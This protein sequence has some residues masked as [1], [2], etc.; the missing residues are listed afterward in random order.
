MVKLEHIDKYF[1]RFKKNKIHVINDTSLELSEKGLVALLGPSGSGKTTLLN[2][3]GGLD[4]VR[5]GKIW[6]NGQQITNKPQISVDRIRNLNV[7]YIFQDYKLIDNLSVYENVSIVLKMIGIKDKKEIDKRVR[8]VLDKV[9]MLRYKKRPCSMLSGG[10]RQRVGIARAI[11]KNPNIIIADEPTGNLD[12]KNSIEIMNIIKSISKDKLVILVT[13]E[14]SLAKFYATRILELEDGKIIKDYINEN[15]QELN[16]ENSNS[17]YLRDYK[18]LCKYNEDIKVYS[19]TPNNLKINIVV[20][21]N[22]IYIE[23]LDNKKIEI[24]DDNS[25]LKMVDDHYKNFSKKELE[26]YEFDYQQIINNPKKLKYSSIFNPL[27][28]ITNGFQ[29]V[30]NYSILKKILLIGFFLSG[31]FILYGTSSIISTLTIKD[32]Q[33]VTMNKN[34]LIIRTKKIKLD[35]YQTYENNLEAEYILPTNSIIKLN[36]KDDSFYQS[37]K[38]IIPIEGSLTSISTIA[39]SDLV[40]GRMPVAEN[41]I[42]VDKLT[43]NKTI[44]TETAK[45]LGITKTKDFLEKTII[46]PNMPDFKIVGIVNK[47]SPSIYA[48]KNIFINLLHHTNTNQEEETD[49]DLG[50]QD[51]EALEFD[52]F[53]LYTNKVELKEGRWPVNDYETIVNINHKEEY[54]INKP[55]NKSIQNQ[56]LIVVGYYSPKDEMDTYLINNNMIKIKV[57]EKSSDISVYSN[58]KNKTL[59]IGREQYHLNINDSYTNSKEQYIKSRR[60]MVKT[61]LISSSIILAISLIEILLMIRASFLSRIK[62]VGIYR[63]IGI[64]KEDIYIMFS[65]EIIAITTIASIPGILISAYI[66]KQLSKISYL[67][68]TIIINPQIVLFSII[69]IYIFNLVIGLIPVANTIRKRPAEILSR[70]DI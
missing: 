2:T 48:S 34:Y 47:K 10:E 9:G 21:N 45:M 3:I 19:N 7:G 51:M 57:I 8:Y 6:I 61:S 52:D 56:K 20:T 18:Y 13:H 43:L 31:I 24:V 12:S 1:N 36:V 42:I 40:K 63:A 70:T 29:K 58:N 65:G 14:Q 33:F 44:K 4:E 55:I 50:E 26:K 49:M 68:D 60:E 69:I 23:T 32:N 66:L 16:Y 35:D 59:K 28:F 11:V 54:K 22:N 27:T 25:A 46:I 15:Q 62:E 67:K 64:K 17:L 39:E 37:S 53:N 41:E 38:H 30:R 5:K